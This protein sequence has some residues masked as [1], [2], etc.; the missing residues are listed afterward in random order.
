MEPRFEGDTLVKNSSKSLLVSP[1]VRE[2]EQQFHTTTCHEASNMI[3]EPK[4]QIIHD[5]YVEKGG[6]TTSTSG[7]IYDL[8]SK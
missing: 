4:S 7:P 2:N 6:T 3:V 8:F 1:E 5:I